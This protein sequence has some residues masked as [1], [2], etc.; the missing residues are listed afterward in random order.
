MRGHLQGALE[1]A[2]P[3]VHGGVGRRAEQQ[4]AVGEHA[5]DAAAV[6]AVLARQLAQCARVVL[7]QRSGPEKD[8]KETLK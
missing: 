2:I 4:A 8:T 7:D 6:R 5:G 3:N 1:L